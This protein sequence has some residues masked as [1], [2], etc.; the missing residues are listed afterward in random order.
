[1]TWSVGKVKYIGTSAM[2]LCMGVR[3]KERPYKHTKIN[4]YGTYTIKPLS[5]PGQYQES[6]LSMA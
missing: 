1:V 5:Q 4:S 2:S 6:V 3:E